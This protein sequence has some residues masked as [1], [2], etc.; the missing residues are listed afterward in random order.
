MSKCIRCNSNAINP[1]LHGRESDVDLDLC[2]VCY[3]RKRAEDCSY[4]LEK[5]NDQ[6]DYWRSLSR[7]YARNLI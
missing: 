6:L 4:A 7:R 3:W 5:C 2:D 1:N